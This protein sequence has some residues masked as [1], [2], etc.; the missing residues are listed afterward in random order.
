MRIMAK[1]ESQNS[2]LT[3]IIIF[4]VIIVGV[5]LMVFFALRGNNASSSVS[6]NEGKIVPSSTIQQLADVPM[7]NIK[8]SLSTK[9]STAL[10]S[11]SYPTPITKN[12][13][14]EVLYV[15]AEY[16]PFC[17]AERWAI[18]IALSKFGSFSNL[19]Y[20]QSSS[21]DIDPNTSTF[22]F[23]GSNYTSKYISFVP[24]ETYT[25]VADPNGGYT[26]LQSLTSSESTLFNHFDAPPYVS[27]SSA[28]S[29][30]FVDIANK[31]ILIGAQYVPDVLQSKNWNEIL[32]AIGTPNSS[33]SN[34]ILSAS[35]YLIQDIC[36]ATNGQPSN[37]CSK[38]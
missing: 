26:P 10:Q 32:S 17:A 3:F 20:I 12:G 19:H 14:P 38:I 29:I 28:G 15:G 8:N 23:Y 7:S 6:S 30:P 16:C 21:S 25:N 9:A 34:D 22:S 27:S 4:V 2:I 36:K 31:Y 1:R 18:I 37:V 13:L 24:V 33:I 35:G 11:V 5:F